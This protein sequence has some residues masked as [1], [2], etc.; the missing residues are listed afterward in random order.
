MRIVTLS[1]GIGK[2]IPRAALLG[3]L[4]WTAYSVTSVPHETPLPRPV[5][6]Q[7]GNIDSIGAG[8][9]A[10][11]EMGPEDGEPVLFVHGVHAA[12]SAFDIRPLYTA[13]ATRGRRVVALDLPGFGH[14]QRG[15]RDYSQTLMATAIS[16]VAEQVVGGQVDVV[17]LSLGSEFAARAAR[18]RPE[19]IRSLTMISPTGFSTAGGGGNPAWL[20]ALVRA[21]VIGT[22]IFDLIASR[23]SISY[24]LGLNFFGETDPAFETFAWLTA[25]Q[26]GAR[27]APAAF[28]SG[29]LFDAEAVERLYARVEQPVLVL[30]DEDPHTSFARLPEFVDRFG[31]SAR[32]VGPSRGLPHFEALDATIDALERFWNG[33]RG[34]A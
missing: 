4:G 33:T 31:W 22:A 11:Y 16:D 27:H 18:D 15:D 10:V 8:A 21:P 9:V 13:L 32:R 12:A 1:R 20:G 26:P 14:S 2:C 29:Q 34:G 24:F 25:H 23:P 3:G 19:S 6:G 30:Y 5:P 28:L 7:A 17:A